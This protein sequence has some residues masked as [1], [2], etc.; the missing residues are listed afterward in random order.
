MARITAASCSYW[1]VGGKKHSEYVIEYLCAIFPIFRP[2]F[3]SYALRPMPYALRPMPYAL[4]PMP[5]ALCPTTYALCPTPDLSLGHLFLLLLQAPLV[6][7]PQARVRVGVRVRCVR[8]FCDFS[9][10]EI[11]GNRTGE[12]RI[13]G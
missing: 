5:Y 13:L 12:G 4:Y 6:R 3:A 7:L 2:E 9:R 10:T 11:S 1:S 8:R